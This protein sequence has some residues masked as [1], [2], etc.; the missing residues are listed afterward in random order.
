MSRKPCP[1]LVFGSFP[2]AL[3][4]RKWRCQRAHISLRAV[5]FCSSPL[6]FFFFANSP[7][8]VL[9]CQT[10]SAR[11]REPAFS[12]RF[13]PRA[14]FRGRRRG[15]P[16]GT[17]VLCPADGGSPSTPLR[18]GKP[19]GR[20]AAAGKTWKKFGLAK[21]PNLCPARMQ[22]REPGSERPA[23]AALPS[24]AACAGGESPWLLSPGRPHCRPPRTGRRSEVLGLWVLSPKFK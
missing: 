21:Q 2:P 13:W 7:G 4:R 3:E 19:E 11:D 12:S 20:I 5:F 1:S 18:T 15:P 6:S 9:G 8:S 16:G 10:S 17:A 23:V 14:A 22:C 24:A